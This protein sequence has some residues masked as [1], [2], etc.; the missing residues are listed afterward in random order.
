[1]LLAHNVYFTLKDNSPAACRR[2]VEACKKYLTV[3]KGI[4]YFACG[5]LEPELAR[6]V[7]VRDFDVG[8]HI[9]FADRA[10]HDAYQDDPTHIRFIEENKANWTKVRVFDTLVESVATRG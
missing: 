6:D 3:Q 4:V 9:V 5:V 7:N 10:A 2:L 8:L 1:M